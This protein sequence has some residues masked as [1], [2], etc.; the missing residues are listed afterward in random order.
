MSALLLIAGAA[1]DNYG[2]RRLLV[3]GTALFLL[4]SLL[5]ALAPS[6]ELLL[7]GRALQGVGAAMLM[8]NSLAILGDAFSGER[9]GRAIGTWAAA[10]AAA[11]AAAPLL[12]GWLVDGAGW[13][14]IFLLNLPIG[15]AAI[16]LTLRYVPESAN[17]DRPPPDWL[18]A[19]LATSGLAALTWGLT[20]WTARG[21]VTAASGTALVGGAG[22]LLVFLIAEARRG[23][24]AMVPL[25][26]F[27][28]R[29]FV[30][31]TLLTFL[32]YGAFGG[33]MVLLPYVLIEAAGYSS[34]QAGMALLP[35]PIVI[36]LASRFMGRVAER[37]GP[38]WPLGIGPLLV[39]AGFLLAARIGPAADYASEVLPALVL[40]S[41][42]MAAAVAPLTTA[43]LSSVDGRHSGTASGLN[44]AVARTGGMIATA[45]LGLVLGLEGG[46]LVEGFR[47]A[48]LA[49]AAL[50]L[51]AAACALLLERRSAP[52]AV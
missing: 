49:G 18:G 9:R 2:R 22:L 7:A 23:E 13:P 39:A 17:R 12:G 11:G 44:S 8:P 43:V 30:G 48:A 14:A 40:L 15:L 41:L 6:L 32:L 1:G 46:A 25:T 10:G 27:G 26:M 3:W 16:L 19:S 35:L 52:A 29:G 21:A 42:G 45:L 28:S 5:C 47:G 20:S 4:A 51:G 33:L 38:A 31:L 24:R 34:L 37:I 36:A 50:A